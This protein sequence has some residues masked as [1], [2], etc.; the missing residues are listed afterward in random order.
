VNLR[1]APRVWFR[2]GN[3]PDAKPS[4]NSNG[5]MVGASERY[6][7]GINDSGQVVGASYTDIRAPWKDLARGCAGDF[8]SIRL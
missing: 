3:R 5:Q 8:R 7:L 6:D 4:I 2:P 1:A